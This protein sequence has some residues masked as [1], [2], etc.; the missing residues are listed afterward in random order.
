MSQGLGKVLE[1]CNFGGNPGKTTKKQHNSGI[2]MDTG[3]WKCPEI[4]KFYGAWSLEKPDNNIEILNFMDI[5]TS[6]CLESP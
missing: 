2:F 6:K 4:L 5:G 1:F 3:A